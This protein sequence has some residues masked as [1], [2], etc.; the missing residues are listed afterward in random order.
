MG[1]PEW[2]DALLEPDRQVEFHGVKILVE[3]TEDE[4]LPLK[5]DFAE[6]KQEE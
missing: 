3:I 4:R 6:E 2:D 5:K 1:V